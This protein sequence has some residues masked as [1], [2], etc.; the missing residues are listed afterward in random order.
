MVKNP[1]AMQETPVQIPRLGRSAGEEIGYPF[2][3]YWAALLVQLIKNPT[4]MWETWVQSLSWEDLLEKGK[5]TYSSI[6]VYRIP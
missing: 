6:Q 4:A 2:Q 1:P 3:Y 5:A